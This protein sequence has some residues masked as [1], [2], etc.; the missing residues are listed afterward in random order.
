MLAAKVKQNSKIKGIQV[1]DPD[2][3]NP[4]IIDIRITQF[5]DDTTIFLDS[6]NSVNKVMK[7]VEILGDNAGPKINWSKSKFIKLNIDVQ[8]TDKLHFT[9]DSIKCLG[10]YVGKCYKEVEN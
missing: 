6:V 8:N 4:E 2:L 7:E 3:D 1:P 10:V 5:A 9:E